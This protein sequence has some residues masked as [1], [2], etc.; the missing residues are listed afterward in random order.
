MPAPQ[1]TEPETACLVAMPARQMD[2]SDAIKVAELDRAPWRRLGVCGLRAA[3]D[4]LI[5][6]NGCVVR[7][8]YRCG[9]GTVVRRAAAPGHPLVARECLQCAPT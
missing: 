5:V 2:V 7:L 3:S 6:T 1:D 4:Y 9:P 8:G